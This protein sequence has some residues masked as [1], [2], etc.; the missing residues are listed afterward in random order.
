M[1]HDLRARHYNVI[2]YLIR[3]RDLYLSIAEF[4]QLFALYYTLINIHV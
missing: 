3:P 4:L 2:Y 1:I